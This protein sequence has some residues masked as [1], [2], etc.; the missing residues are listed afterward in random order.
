MQDNALIVIIKRI[1][2]FN[3]TSHNGPQ[4]YIR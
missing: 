1:E 2:I 3:V 4:S